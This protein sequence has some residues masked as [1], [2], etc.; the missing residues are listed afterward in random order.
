MNK[1][2]CPNCG[3]K[4]SKDTLTC[5]HCGYSFQQ[6]KP[7]ARKQ[8]QP[9]AKKPRTFTYI[10]L[11]LL[12]LLIII[13]G[14]FFFQGSHSQNAQGP[15]RSSANSSSASSAS[16]SGQAD[17][18]SDK[19]SE[20][21][22]YDESFTWNDDTAENFDGDFNDWADRM[23]QSYSSGST[24]FDGVSYPEDFRSKTFIVNGSKATLAMHGS[25]HRSDYRVVEIRYDTDQGYLYL[26][27]FHNGT[28]IVLFT[29]N[30][31]AAGGQVSFKTTANSEL[32]SLFAN[33]GSN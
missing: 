3:Q 33:Y 27:A 7:A 8:G 12:A 5:P 4:V 10:M 11:A 13:G 22:T 25:S 20:S 28:P 16:S 23:H 24:E 15:S 29:Q 9:T 30:G 32:R 18:S 21:G 14:I 1:K 2:Y 6:A 26:F 19:S 17:S 31:D